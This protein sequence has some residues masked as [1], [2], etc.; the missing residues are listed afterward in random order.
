MQ[1]LNTQ[2]QLLAELFLEKVK[3]IKKKESGRYPGSLAYKKKVL[4]SA[5]ICLQS[6]LSY[7]YLVSL[8][9]ESSEEDS[10]CYDLVEFVHSKNPSVQINSV[11]EIKRN[12]NEC[13]E[14]GE[15]YYHPLLQ[16]SSQPPRYELDMK[17]MKFKESPREP[18]FLEMKESF[19]LEDLTM[20]YIKEAEVDG[21]Y[22]PR[23]YSSFKK[24]VD[25][26][27]IDLTLYLIDAS[28]AK[29]K[30]NQEPA[31]IHPSFLLEN[32]EEAKTMYN[33]RKEISAEGGL[34]HV[35]PRQQTASC[36]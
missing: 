27:G 18:F 6:N 30:D 11:K 13:M 5:H 1:N 34:T 32:L 35:Y 17:T 2:T 12:P 33:N 29:A 28:V 23:Y 15:F 22:P 3:R 4:E 14:L 24:V 8:I 36:T 19:T 26:Y 16:F 21:T 9:T 25:M 7:D 31:P 20:Y 10:T